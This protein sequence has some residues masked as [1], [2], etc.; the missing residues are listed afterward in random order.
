M[1][2]LTTPRTLAECSFPV[3]YAEAR[4]RRDNVI[5]VA[6]MVATLLACALIGVM[7]AWRG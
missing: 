3:G 2:N 4:T 1:K 7:L 5:D 6:C